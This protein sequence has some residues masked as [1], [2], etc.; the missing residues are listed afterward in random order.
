MTGEESKLKRSIRTKRR[1]TLLCPG[2]KSNYLNLHQI[3]V[4][5]L[6]TDLCCTGTHIPSSVMCLSNCR[7]SLERRLRVDETPDLLE[8][9]FFLRWS[10]PYCSFLHHS[11]LGYASSVPAYRNTVELDRNQKGHYG[12]SLWPKVIPYFKECLHSSKSA[13]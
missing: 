8:S 6:A 2:M 1:S 12:P 4:I 10:V 3:L 5:V 13:R 7:L 11:N 9:I